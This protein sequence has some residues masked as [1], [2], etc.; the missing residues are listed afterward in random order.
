MRRLNGILVSLLL[1]AGLVLH[2]AGKDEP[3]KTEKKTEAERTKAADAWVERFAKGLP[4]NVPRWPDVFAAL[5]RKYGFGKVPC[6]VFDSAREK[7]FRDFLA[8]WAMNEGYS[9]EPTR[10]GFT[11]TTELPTTWT[12]GGR[13]RKGCLEK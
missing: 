13:K 12:L 6:G 8:P 1:G 10:E 9:L 7:Y 11:K 2:A 3:K 4:D 5:E